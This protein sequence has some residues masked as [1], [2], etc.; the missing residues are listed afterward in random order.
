MLSVIVLTACDDFV[1]PFEPTDR[2]TDGPLEDPSTAELQVNSV[3]ALFEC[4]YSAFD[5]IALGH[6][7][8]LE[9]NAGIAT[10]T[11]VYLAEALSGE[12]DTS[13]ANGSWFGGMMGARVLATNA[14]ETGVYDRLQGEWTDADVPNR[15]RLSAS[16]AIYVAAAFGHFGEF[17]CEMAFDGGPLTA[18]DAVLS[19]A[20]QWAEK[21]IGHIAAAGGDFEMPFGISNSAEMMA[22][23][24]RAR[25]RW[26]RGDMSGALADA[27]V[28][29]QGFT[30]WV[31]REPGPT[32]RNKIYSSGSSGT[33]STMGGINDWWD[34]SIRRPNP[35]TGQLWPD[36]VPFTGYL[37]LG[38]LPDGRAVDEDGYAVRWAEEL[39]DS[40]NGNPVPLGNGA[41]P[42][43]RVQHSARIRAGPGQ[44]EA[45]EKY[46]SDADDIPLVSW[47]E[48]WLI[49]AEIEG[50]QTAI[51]LV[52]DLRTAAGLP[53]V[54]YISGGTASVQ[55]I[56]YMILE[57][58]RR[59]LFSEGGRY[60]ATKIRNTDVLWFP[61]GEGQTPFQGY[62]LRG[63]VRL[64]MPSLEYEANRNLGLEDMATGCNPNEAP[65]L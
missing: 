10:G 23:A 35:A 63:G 61:R 45:P 1:D 21:A 64:T 3:I 25:L 39:R 46:G 60:W 15:A 43:T 12:C 17:Y 42:D 30:A 33:Y 59:A 20:E 16:A 7:D 52:N 36:P 6:E 38:I 51:D 55:D 58:W 29:P 28:I 18:P 44:V 19:E 34:P 37:F 50:G 56:R 14:N 31:T 11:H 5:W 9:S 49:R 65:V 4:A 2:I 26:A 13:D 47:K 54:S 57:E 53:T 48:M 24:L 62:S 40:N 32:R 27:Q 22:L 8:V 41:V